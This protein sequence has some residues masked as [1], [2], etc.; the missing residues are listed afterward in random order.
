MCVNA[1]RE[2]GLSSGPQVLTK[3]AVEA[4]HRM[5]PF[6]EEEGTLQRHR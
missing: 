6:L 2:K 3:G 1:L 5:P 4:L